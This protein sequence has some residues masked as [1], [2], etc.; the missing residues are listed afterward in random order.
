VKKLF[1]FGLAL[2]LVFEV[3]K[4]I[5][6]IKNTLNCVDGVFVNRDARNTNFVHY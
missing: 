2:L 5:F 1:Y 3:R 4:Q 6:Y